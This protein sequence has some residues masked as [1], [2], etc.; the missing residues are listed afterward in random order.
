MLYYFV[1]KYY[2]KFV[3]NMEK[4]NLK[5]EPAKEIFQ[6]GD[7]LLSEG[8]W[9]K[10]VRRRSFHTP[11]GKRETHRMEAEYIIREEGG[12]IVEE[13]VPGTEKDRGMATLQELG[14]LMEERSVRKISK[15]AA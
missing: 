2:N 9:G 11:V 4:G 8:N 12:R 15:K 5:E 3:E 10:H 1:E 14:Q 6:P 7:T 13:K